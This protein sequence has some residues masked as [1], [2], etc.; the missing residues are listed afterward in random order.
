MGRI[1]GVYTV[2]ATFLQAWSVEC[3]VWSEGIAFGDDSN[4]S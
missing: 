3:E 4:N 1:L 2:S